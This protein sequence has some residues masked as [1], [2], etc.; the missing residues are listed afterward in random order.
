MIKYYYE[1]EL[2]SQNLT[3]KTDIVWA[4]D[5]TTLDLKLKNDPNT[6]ELNILLIID[7]H[8]NFIL[9]FST[10]AKTITASGTVRII[11]NAVLDAF[12]FIYE[13]GE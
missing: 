3:A 4:T 2:A 7:I 13:E 5:F 9:G 10:S 11:K 12:P 6:P 1:N 8:T